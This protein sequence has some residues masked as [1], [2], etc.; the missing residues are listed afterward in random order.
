[1][2][3]DKQDSLTNI[4]LLRSSTVKLP[5]FPDDELMTGLQM[6]I[7]KINELERGVCISLCFVVNKAEVDDEIKSDKTGDHI[8]RE[9]IGIDKFTIE[10]SGEV[11]YLMMQ[12]NFSM[13]FDTVNYPFDQSHIRL[14][15]NDEKLGS[16]LISCKIHLSAMITENWYIDSLDR[17]ESGIDL[18]LTRIK[19][20]GFYTLIIPQL[21]ISLMGSSSYM[22]K[23]ESSASEMVMTATLSLVAFKAYSSTLMSQTS[24]L[25]ITDKVSLIS[26]TYMGLLI[27]LINIEYQIPF[28][29]YIVC[30]SLIIIYLI[31]VLLII[32][33][34]DRGVIVRISEISL[35]KEDDD[36][37]ESRCINVKFRR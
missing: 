17:T 20:H 15:L 7:T 18:S 8:F 2:S 26:M 1:M 10:A 4:Q 24:N 19:S 30:V 3:L 34:R 31:S 21:L 14:T 9:S 12:G 27:I 33:W 32:Q 25:T 35:H 28:P 16:A 22:F 6:E 11:Y 37:R 5:S 13:D 23:E 29:N 36:W